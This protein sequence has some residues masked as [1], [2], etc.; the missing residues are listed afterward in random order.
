MTRETVIIYYDLLDP[1]VDPEGKYR[2]EVEV[3]WT[4]IFTSLRGTGAPACISLTSPGTDAAEYTLIGHPE[5]FTNGQ[6]VEPEA[7]T[8]TFIMPLHIGQDRELAI[9]L[10]GD[11]LRHTGSVL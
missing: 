2:E 4:G 6:V 1:E 9:A 10:I 3:L 11:L 7:D 5:P 8:S